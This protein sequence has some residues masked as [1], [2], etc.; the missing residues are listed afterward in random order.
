[1]KC[2]KCNVDMKIKDVKFVQR[3]DGTFAQRMRL[4][5]IS[6]NCENFGKIV[7]TV[8]IPEKVEIEG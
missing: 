2:P 3:P 8:Y 5:C 7:E 6:K 1:V 4:E